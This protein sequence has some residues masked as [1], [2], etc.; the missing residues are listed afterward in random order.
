MAERTVESLLKEGA[1]KRAVT[2]VNTEQASSEY[3]PKGVWSGRADHVTAKATDSGLRFGGDAG[4]SRG[5]GDGT[6]VKGK[7]GTRE[8]LPGSPRRAK[9]TRIRDRP[10]TRG[11][12]RESEG[13]VVPEKAERTR[14][15]EGTLL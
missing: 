8:A 3:Q 15:R 2:R 12:R 9:T 6:L 7:G 14:W 4:R 13:F 11:A 1:G 10:K 5:I